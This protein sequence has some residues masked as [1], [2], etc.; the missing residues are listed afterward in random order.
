MRSCVV[1][2]RGRSY[3]PGA[4]VVRVRGE[5]LEA[6]QREGGRRGQA[7][8][9]AA[10]VLV[11]VVVVVVAAIV[12]VAGQHHVPKLLLDV[13]EA[14]ALHL[15]VARAVQLEGGARS[16]ARRRGGKRRGRG[17]VTNW[18][19]QNMSIKKCPKRI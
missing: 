5:S 14:A 19:K 4:I 3:H 7:R 15:G 16:A 10:V 9:V 1:W 17:Y 2:V 6:R 8:A 12:A 18:R 11:V 13:V